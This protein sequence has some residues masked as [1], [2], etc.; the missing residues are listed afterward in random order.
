MLDC[1]GRSAHNVDAVTEV[2]AVWFWIDS[3]IPETLG[4]IDSEDKLLKAIRLAL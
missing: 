4:W 3:V 1:T 2:G